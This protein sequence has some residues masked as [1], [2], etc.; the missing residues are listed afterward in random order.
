MHNW[1]IVAAIIIACELFSVALFTSVARWSKSSK[2]VTA[3]SVAKGI[4]ERI[5]IVFALLSDYP[6]ALTLFAALKIGTRI[7]DDNR[8]SNDYYLVGNLVSV[9]LAIAYTLLIQHLF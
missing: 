9:S 7:K 6:Q 8:I 3:G 5:F 2:K 4:F 1:I